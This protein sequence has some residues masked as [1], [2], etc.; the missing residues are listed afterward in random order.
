MEDIEE[1]I[2]NTEITISKLNAFIALSLR[3][4]KLS[5]E[6]EQLTLDSIKVRDLMTEAHELMQREFNA[7]E[8]D[9]KEVMSQ[10]R[11]KQIR[12]MDYIIKE[13]QRK[14]KE[15]EEED[16][17]VQLILSCG[18]SNTKLNSA[19]K[20]NNTASKSAINK[21]GVNLAKLNLNHVLSGTPKIKISE[22]KDSPMVKKRINP[23][24]FQFEEFD[25][26]ITQQQFDTIPKYV[27]TYVI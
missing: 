7:L 5:K 9:Y 18:K 24:L 4:T 22:Y 23:V 14:I 11:K 19:M 17:K 6:L 1:Q 16:K 21:L 12:I 8:D 20:A 10:M 26:T 15:A 27:H 13:K 2:Q 3:R 25:V